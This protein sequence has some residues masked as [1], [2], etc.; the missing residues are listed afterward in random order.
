MQKTEKYTLSNDDILEE[1][2]DF[3]AKK[4]VAA[5]QEEKDRFT[6]ILAALYRDTSPVNVTGTIPT[7]CDGKEQYAFEAWAASE[8][9]DMHQHPL[10]YLF[11][12]KCTDSARQGWKAAIQYVREVVGG[13]R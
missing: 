7:V 13:P 9:Y 3:M 6:S 4:G 10:H 12:D 11:M 2:V 8:R 1:I 5:S